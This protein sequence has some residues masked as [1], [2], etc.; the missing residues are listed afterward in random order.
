TILYRAGPAFGHRSV[1][2]QPVS[3]VVVV[4]FWVY[5]CVMGF[6][7]L[8]SFGF[9][10]GI[11]RSLLVLTPTKVAFSASS[12]GFDSGKLG[13]ISEFVRLCF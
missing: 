4:F 5:S 9:R 13:F 6:S 2:S 3:F 12:A 1:E 7:D 8:S 11:C 10:L